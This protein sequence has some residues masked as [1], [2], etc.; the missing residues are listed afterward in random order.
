VKNILPTILFLSPEGRDG[1]RILGVVNAGVQV[2]M[3]L[4]PPQMDGS[5]TEDAHWDAMQMHN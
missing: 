3:G 5:R 4:S 1:G 2:S